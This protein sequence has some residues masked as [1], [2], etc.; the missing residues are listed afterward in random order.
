MGVGDYPA[1]TLEVP[2]TW[3]ANGAFVTRGSNG[4]SVWDVGDV[5]RNPCHWQSTMSDP[6]PTVDDLVEALTAQR[7]RHA[8]NRPT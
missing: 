7:F 8:R 4:V 6:G 3:A 2:A 1:F 5:P